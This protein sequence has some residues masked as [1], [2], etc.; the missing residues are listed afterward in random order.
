[1]V[2]LLPEPRK[3]AYGQGLFTLNRDTVLAMDA[4]GT[5]NLLRSV[6]M[7]KEDIKRKL[8]YDL[9]IVKALEPL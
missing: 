8:C 9:S 3:I 6:R 2:A 1:M 5:E 4:S 7:V